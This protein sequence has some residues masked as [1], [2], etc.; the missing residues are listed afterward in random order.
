M[1]KTQ[2]GFDTSGKS[3]A[4]ILASNKDAWYSLPC[5][6]SA[7]II[8]RSLRT[9]YDKKKIDNIKILKI[10]RKKIIV[11]IMRISQYFAFGQRKCL[12]DEQFLRSESNMNPKSHLQVAWVDADGKQTCSHPPFII[13][14]GPGVKKNV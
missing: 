12:P 4:V 3:R 2:A 11:Y 7:I 1:Y 5:V 13:S 8:N 9:S 6:W 10:S 14:Q